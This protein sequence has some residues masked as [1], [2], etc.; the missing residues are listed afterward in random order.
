MTKTYAR[1]WKKS[2]G[3]I[4]QCGQRMHLVAVGLVGRGH[5]HGQQMTQHIDRIGYDKA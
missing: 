3:L 2:W 4:D 5:R 1:R